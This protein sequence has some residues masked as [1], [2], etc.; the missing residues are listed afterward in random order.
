MKSIKTQ[1][2]SVVLCAVLGT[3]LILLGI[4]VFSIRILN[5][6]DSDLLLEY[7]VRETSSI[8]NSALSATEQSVQSVSYYALEQLDGNLDRLRSDSAWRNDYL[9]GV[10]SIAL[11]EAGSGRDI[12]AVYFRLNTAFGAPAGFLYQYYEGTGKLEK[13]LLTDISAYDKDD[14]GHV[15]WYYEPQKAKKPLWLG[16]Y[17]NYNL[18]MRILSYEVPVYYEDTFIGVIGMDINTKVTNRDLANIHAYQTGSAVLF[19]KDCNIVYHK[20]HV[21]GLARARFSE[22]HEAILQAALQAVRT[23]APVEYNGKNDKLFATYLQDGMILCLTAPTEEINATQRTVVGWSVLGS[24]SVLAVILLVAMLQ[25][26]TFLKPLQELTRAAE[27]LADGNMEVSFRTSHPAGTDNEIAKLADT[28][29]TMA[30]SL[31]RYFDHFHSLAYTDNMTG[32]N[33]KAAFDMTRD[34]IE[35]E[36][37]MGRASFTI[38]VMDVNNLKTINDSIGHEKGDMLLKHCT[39]CMRETFVGYPL[40]R[41]G[42]DE[43]CSIINNSADPAALIAQ[44]QARTAAKSEQDF[45]VF[46]VSYQIA[47]GSAVYD[48]A[49]DKSFQDVFNRADAAMYE[50]KRALKA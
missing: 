42:G 38:V 27:K 10:E 5:R 13:R 18:K 46:R 33:N 48:R 49:C 11:T 36:V 19:D 45:S 17:D 26:N 21:R 16:P 4:S 22:A 30:S 20:S 34:V 44:L 43:F 9:N 12:E 2:L 31:K 25:I 28:F 40:Y 32:L 14:F 8:I 15:G 3:T 23:S 37:K 35:S 6:N 7:I 50:N 41:I 29:E 1:V 24:V 47:A 39:Q